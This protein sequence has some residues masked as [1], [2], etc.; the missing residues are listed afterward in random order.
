MPSLGTERILSYMSYIKK[1]PKIERNFI[2]KLY[3]LQLDERQYAVLKF[4]TFGLWKN[5]QKKVR[6]QISDLCRKHPKW[7]AKYRKFMFN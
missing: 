4:L 5:P 3:N 2:I 1:L 6:K 7:V